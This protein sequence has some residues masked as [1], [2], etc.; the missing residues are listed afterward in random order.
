MFS[1]LLC[2]YT[3]AQAGGD[4]TSDVKSE[5]RLIVLLKRQLETCVMVP[6][7]RSSMYGA[8]QVP[9]LTRTKNTTQKPKCRIPYCVN[10]CRVVGVVL[11]RR[12]C[13]RQHNTRVLRPPYCG[14]RT[15]ILKM[16]YVDK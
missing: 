1:L 4:M 11:C 10:C 3:E 14:S 6:E 2:F 7:E 12:Q 15:F 8:V 13:A 16:N 5:L 9:P